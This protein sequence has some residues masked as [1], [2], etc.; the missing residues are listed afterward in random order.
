LQPD[1]PFP[2]QLL[3]DP[4]ALEVLDAQWRDAHEQPS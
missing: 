4:G 1:Q 3:V 2:Q